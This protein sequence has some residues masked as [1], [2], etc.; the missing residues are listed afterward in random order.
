MRVVSWNIRGMG[1][2]TEKGREKWDT[3][4]KGEFFRGVIILLQETKI[5]EEDV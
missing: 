3:I 1:F 4:V 2:K 5:M